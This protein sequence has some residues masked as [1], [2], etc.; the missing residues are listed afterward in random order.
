MDRACGDD[1]LESMLEMRK[2][3]QAEFIPFLTPGL[4][5]ESQRIVLRDCVGHL[6]ASIYSVEELFPESDWHSLT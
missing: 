4:L 2:L 6:L 3:V 5:V 1:I